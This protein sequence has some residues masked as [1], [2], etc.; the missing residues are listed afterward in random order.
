[1]TFS[2]IFRF[3]SFEIKT[4]S[5]EVSFTFL[6]YTL[7]FLESMAFTFLGSFVIIFKMFSRWVYDTESEA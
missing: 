7:I 4:F 2:W 6:Q 5:K 3:L 1:M